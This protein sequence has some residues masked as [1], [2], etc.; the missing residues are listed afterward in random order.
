MAKQLKGDINNDGKI[1]IIDMLTIFMYKSGEIPETGDNSL[2]PDE[3]QRADIDN[4]GSVTL[5]DALA[6]NDHITG[7]AIIDGVIV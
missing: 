1:S 4:D 3:L 6:I 2:N 7:K 5:A